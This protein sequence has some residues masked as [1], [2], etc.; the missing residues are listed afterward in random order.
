MA[1]SNDEIAFVFAVFII[2]YYHN[3]A[4]FYI[5][6]GTFNGVK[7]KGGL[8]KGR[9]RCI[10]FVSPKQQKPLIACLSDGFA[11]EEIVNI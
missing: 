6:Y 11:Y 4:I 3:S 10:L 5:F 8:C 7:H 1:G 9:L 2:Y